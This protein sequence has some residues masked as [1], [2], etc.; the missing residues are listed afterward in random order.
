MFIITLYPRKREADNRSASQEIPSLFTEKKGPLRHPPK[1]A[2]RPQP[3]PAESSTNLISSI[4][5]HYSPSTS[6][7]SDVKDMECRQ[8]NPDLYGV[9]IKKR[10]LSQSEAVAIFYLS[11]Q[12]YGKKDDGR[13]E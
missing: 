8:D 5:Y 9:I 4:S 11:L 13:M 10:V 12:K 2:T 3:Q 1:S 6:R 7:S